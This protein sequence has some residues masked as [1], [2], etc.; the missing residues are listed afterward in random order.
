MDTGCLTCPFEENNVEQKKT[1]GVS[2]RGFFL[3]FD[4]YGFK[5]SQQVS[6]MSRAT[7]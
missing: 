1:A 4:A 2:T 3:A 6:I 7:T 5:A